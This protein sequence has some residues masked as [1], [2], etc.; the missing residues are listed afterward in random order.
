VL[1]LELLLVT[2]WTYFVHKFKN[3]P[4]FLSISYTRRVKEVLFESGER[5]NIHCKTTG[6]ELYLFTICLKYAKAPF[7]LIHFLHSLKNS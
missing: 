7:Y 3:S 4:T 5:I 6:S 1:E 2:I